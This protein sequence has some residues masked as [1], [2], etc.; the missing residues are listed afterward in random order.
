[1]LIYLDVITDQFFSM[2]SSNTLL[3]SDVSGDMNFSS[4][5]KEKAFD[6]IS[7][8]EMLNRLK[9]IVKKSVSFIV[10]RGKLSYKFF[11]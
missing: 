9:F 1:M 5:N 7:P 11:L 10:S 2:F 6:L 8:K 3:N 4:S